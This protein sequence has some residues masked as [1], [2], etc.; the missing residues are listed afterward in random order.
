VAILCW[1]DIVRRQFIQS[2]KC[3]TWD[4]AMINL[5]LA[6]ALGVTMLGQQPDFSGIKWNID[7]VYGIGGTRFVWTTQAS[8]RTL[9]T[10]SPNADGTVTLRIGVPVDAIEE[11]LP[12][13]LAEPIDVPGIVGHKNM[14]VEDAPLPTGRDQHCHLEYPTCADPTRILMHDEQTPPKWWCHRVSP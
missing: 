3:R 14:C 11:P 4:A 12:L 8:A 1:L 10:L 13:T 6:I 2:I 5:G 9:F 7:K